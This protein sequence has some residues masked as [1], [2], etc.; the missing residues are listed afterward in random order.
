MITQKPRKQRHVLPLHDGVDIIEIDSD[1]LRGPISVSV[2]GARPHHVASVGVTGPGFDST[3]TRPHYVASVSVTVR[4][5]GIAGAASFNITG[6]TELGLR[7]FRQPTTRRILDPLKNISIP[8]PSITVPQI[9]TSHRPESTIVKRSNNKLLKA[10]E[11]LTSAWYASLDQMSPLYHLIISSTRNLYIV[12]YLK[13]HPNGT[14]T[15]LASTWKNRDAD[16]RKK[17][18]DLSKEYAKA[19]KKGMTIAQDEI[20]E[21]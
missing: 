5:L 18:D 19:R 3:D 1:G 15:E 4:S 14:E 7:L 16:I 13:I 8:P 12:D 21:Q 6:P 20:N 17:Y 9:T 2:A 11:E 10:K